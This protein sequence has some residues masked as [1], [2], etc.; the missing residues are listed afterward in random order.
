MSKGVS[1]LFHG[2]IGNNALA[3]EMRLQALEAVNKLISDTPGGKRKS[4]ASGAYDLKSG[5]VVAAFAGDIPKKSTQS[6]KKRLK[7]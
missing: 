4:M 3:R 2:T 6:C 7:L 5:K 1:G